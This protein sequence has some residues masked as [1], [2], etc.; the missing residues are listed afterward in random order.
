MRS[1]HDVPVSPQSSSAIEL[2]M[3]H[4]R[5]RVLR[6]V[7]A[8]NIGPAEHVFEARARDHEQASGQRE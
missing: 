4:L 6:S 1:I 2:G 8:A 5:P 7:H 3:G